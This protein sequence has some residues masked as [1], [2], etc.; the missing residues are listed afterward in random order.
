[1]DITL[2]RNRFE[3]PFYIL[4][5]GRNLS[6]TVNSMVKYRFKDVVFLEIV[7]ILYLIGHKRG[8]CDFFPRYVHHGLF[9]HQ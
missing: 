1:M 4:L 5:Y 9:F 8:I 3:Y 6:E 2:D 7:G